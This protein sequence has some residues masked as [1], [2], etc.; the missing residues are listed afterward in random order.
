M[1]VVILAAGRGTRLP[2]EVPKILRRVRDRSLFRHALEQA[3]EVTCTPVVVCQS[4]MRHELRA[5][6]PTR[7]KGTKFSP[8]DYIQQGAALSLLTAAGRLKDDEPVLV[9]DCDTIFA[10]GVLQRFAQFSKSAFAVGKNSTLLTFIPTDDSTRYSFAA[11]DTCEDT[12]YPHVAAVAEKVRISNVATCGVHAFATWAQARQ[13]IFE[14][15]ILGTTT[16]NEYYLAPIHNNIV[17]TTAML[18]DGSEFN[19]VGT[20]EELEAYEQAVPKA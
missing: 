8:V 2:G 15:V 9:M 14:L 1:Q 10:T 18:I 13:A 16:N 3:G 6:V 17:N 4:S 11:V 19:H 5:Q 20:L 7:F 12:T